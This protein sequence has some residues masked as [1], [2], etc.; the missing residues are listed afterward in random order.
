MT[1]ERPGLPAVAIA[2]LATVVALAAVWYL[3]GAD[4]SERT[5]AAD[6][7]DAN[8]AGVDAIASDGAAPAATA[9]T[10]GEAN[11]ATASPF[12][13]DTFGAPAA[14]AAGPLR[15]EREYPTIDYAS[16]PLTGR[17]ERLRRGLA[18]GT[19]R[20]EAGTALEFL[21]QL[22]AE[23][24]IDPSSQTL[25]FSKTSLQ[26]AGILPETPRAIYFNDDTYVAY[27]PGAAFEIASIDPQLGPVFHTIDRDGGGAGALVREANQCL[28]CHDSLSLTGGGVPRL[29]MGSGYIGTQGELVSHEAWI[30]MRP[31]TP[32]RS[33]WG[34]WYVTGQ[35]GDQVHLGNIVVGDIAE[36]NDLEA[37]RVGNLQTLDELLDTSAY[38]TPYSDI[39]ALLVAQHQIQVQNDI[40][41][42]NWDL[43]TA[44]GVPVEDLSLALETMPRD[45]VDQLI[46]EKAEPLI[47]VLVMAFDIELTAPVT[48]TSGFAEWF[49]SQGPVDGDGRSLRDLDLETRIFRYPLSYLVHSTAFDAMPMQ[50][51][52]YVY[53]RVRE[54]LTGGG[55][56]ELEAAYPEDR[57]LAALRILEATKPEFAEQRGAGMAAADAGNLS[58]PGGSDQAVPA[59]N[60]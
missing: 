6:V 37:L 53:R 18:D 13:F 56:L 16:G 23:L 12:D 5:P 10:V 2:G 31:W 20:L 36:L 11:G 57:R 17:I 55:R 51:R 3:V 15:Y 4:R 33:R 21:Q 39:V 43:A 45:E 25:V 27:V 22:L 14:L 59:R 49:R 34:G 30:L 46:F 8:T 42:L 41:R 9:E 32:M 1:G 44:A 29:L 28:R 19:V 52:R 50:A 40:T 58:D 60:Q 35:H 47:E 24:D 38:L 7:A 26:V 48:G 54:E